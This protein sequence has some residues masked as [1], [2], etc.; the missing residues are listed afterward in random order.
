[1][2]SYLRNLTLFVSFYF[3]LLT[4]KK[5]TKFKTKKWSYY[6]FFFI[7]RLKI[8]PEDLLKFYNKK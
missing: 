5:A 6:L 1:M 8:Y 4:Y 7:C 2:F 3:Q